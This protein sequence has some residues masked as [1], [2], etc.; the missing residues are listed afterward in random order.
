MSMT[1]R[2]PTLTIGRATTAGLRV[3]RVDVAGG[4]SAGR[5]TMNASVK[6]ATT[7]P[8]QSV[9]ITS[10]SASV[11]TR[12]EVWLYQWTPEPTLTN[13]AAGRWKEIEHNTGQA[14]GS[15]SIPSPLVLRAA[16]GVG[17]SPL[18]TI[19]AVAAGL[20]VSPDALAARGITV[21]PG[22]K[23][24]LAG[25][26]LT[27]TTLPG[28]PG[29]IAGLSLASATASMVPGEASVGSWDIDAVEGAEPG[30]A[31]DL[32]IDEIHL[33]GLSLPE[34]RDGKV[35]LDDVEL[36]ELSFAVSEIEIPL[37][38]FKVKVATTTTLGLRLG[39]VSIAGVDLHLSLDALTL[40][41]VRVA[42]RLAGVHIGGA[43]APVRLPM[44]AA[45]TV[46]V[47]R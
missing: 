40:G 39:H 31:L 14:S 28:L 44:N 22:E 19:T 42:A 41:D 13:P 7:R 21:P 3:D 25:N 8:E 6:L 32:T 46:E 37:G 16:L 30:A 5:V 24:A 1:V 17:A 27:D 43:G 35:E 18:A 38:A 45:S 20:A 29:T 23:V 9:T 2:I 11:A 15:P 47:H 33:S 4:L 34:A 12:C 10:A 36:P 26:T